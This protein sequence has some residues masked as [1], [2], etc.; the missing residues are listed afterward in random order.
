MSDKSEH[1]SWLPAWFHEDQIDTVIVAFPDIY[2][3]LMGKRL[4]RSHFER[5]VVKSG[6]HACNYLLT[7]DMEMNPLAGYQLASWEQGYGDFHVQPDLSTLRRIPWL[8]GSALVLCDLARDDHTPVAEA[9]RQ[10]LRA[11]L[12]RLAERKW[13]AYMASELEFYL[14]HNSYTDAQAR[15]YHDLT[16]SSDYLIDYHLMQTS[17]DEDI[18]RRL[19]REMDDAGVIIEGSKGEWGKGQHELNLVYAEALEMADRHV[20]FKHGSKE[21]AAQQGRAITYMAKWAADEAG[22]SCH[23]HTSLWDAQGR[24][25]LFWNEKSDEPSQLFRQFLGGLLKYGRELAYFLAPTV[26][27]Y[28]RYQSASWAPTT[29]VWAHDNRTTG[30]RVVGQ[31]P[32][33]RIENRAPGADANP[34]LAYAATLI[35]GL[36]GIEEGLDCGDAYRGNAYADAKLQRLPGSLEEAAGLLANSQLARQAL[37]DSVV[38]FYVLT[39]QHEAQSHRQAVTDWERQRYFERI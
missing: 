1:S 9:P 23:I 24:E 10:V 29:L 11:Q 16:P 15:R 36:A 21:I 14:F 12:A 5:S 33:H 3:R 7:V 13:S 4:S 30:Y 8:P 39:A 26:N 34:Y 32:G 35:A 25:N 28:K 18:I 31:G 17:R 2:G 22:S 19:R 38:E 20:V 6:T 37:G 27:S